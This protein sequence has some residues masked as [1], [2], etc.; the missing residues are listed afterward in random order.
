MRRP[1]CLSRGHSKALSASYCRVFC[2]HHHW[3]SPPGLMAQLIRPSR[4]LCAPVPGALSGGCK[5]LLL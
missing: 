3:G 4:A 2:H 5:L 1:C